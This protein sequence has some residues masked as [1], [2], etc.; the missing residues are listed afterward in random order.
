MVLKAKDFVPLLKE[1][2]GTEFTDI[3]KLLS[4][5]R[6][7]HDY[8]F[9]HET[10]DFEQSWRS[11]KGKGLERVVGYVLEREIAGLDLELLPLSALD[12][13][14]EI[15]FAEYGRHLPDVD[16]AIY[17]PSKDRILAILSIKSSLRERATQTAFWRLKM[18]GFAKT[19][20]V[21]VYL[22]T[23]NSDDILRSDKPSKKQRAVL[24]N[25]IDGTYIVNSPGV[26][27]EEYLYPETQSRLKLIGELVPDL[28]NLALR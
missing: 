24:E 20:D 21:Q 4:V 22:V 26:S 5:A 18:H 8:K 11:V 12:E 3:P 14:I 17:Q 6:D 13:Y 23:P 9:P 1:L 10:K 27:I 16:L 19:R 7:R 15:D 28:Q 2:G 25:D